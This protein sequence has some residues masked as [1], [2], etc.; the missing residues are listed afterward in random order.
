MAVEET[1]EPRVKTRTATVGI[2]A[3]GALLTAAY[4]PMFYSGVTSFDDEGFFLAILRHFLRH[5]SLYDQTRTAYGPFYFSFM[6]AIY[7]VTGQSPTLF[8]GRVITVGLT[9]LSAGVFAAT[10]WRVTRSLSFALLC[11]AVTYAVLIRA[12]G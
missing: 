12:A 3:L 1:T 2:V 10:V 7:R 8:N 4:F 5:G 9:A 6:G 11:E